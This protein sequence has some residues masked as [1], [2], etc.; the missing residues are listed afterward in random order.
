MRLH[1]SGRLNPQA[2]SRALA[3]IT[4]R[5]ESLRT[6]FR[7]PL[8]GLPCQIIDPP[9]RLE[10]PNVDLSRMR[11]LDRQM[12]VHRLT[13]QEAGEAFDLETGPLLRL[14]LLK[15]TTYEHVLFAKVHHIVFDGWSLGVLLRELSVLYATF[16]QGMSTPLPELPVQYAD[17]AVWQRRWLTGAFFEQQ[18]RYWKSRLAGLRPLDLPTDFARP[19]IRNFTTARIPVAL[20]SPLTAALRMVGRRESATLYMV[21]LAAFQLLL[22]RWSGQMDIAV[23]SLVAGRVHSK[24]EALIGFF[25]N[26]LVMRVEIPSDGEFRTL[27]ARVRQVALEAYAHQFVPFERLVLELQA[28]HDRARHPLF[29]VL[30]VLQNTPLA[31]L[32]L[33]EIRATVSPG[34]RRTARYD[35]TLELSEDSGGGLTGY[36]GYA[37]D[38]F[39]V[40]T[41]SR[42][43]TQFRE[44][45]GTIAMSE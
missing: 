35:L 31:R 17:Y 26:I 32:E 12:E 18:L 44:L 11:E 2:L 14:K 19:Q 28:R 4:S 43:E 27:L 9:A 42:F 41:V 30:F 21:L 38:L 1:L 8:A 45:A 20:P 22:F 15:L 40:R 37:T 7:T 10:V 25:V 39:D 24:T 3:E 13:E 33:P 6:R 5:H 23:G 29:Q 36:L 34:E 16:A